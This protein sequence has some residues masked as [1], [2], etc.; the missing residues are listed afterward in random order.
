MR[1]DS[2][3]IGNYFDAGTGNQ[4]GFIARFGGQ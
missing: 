1:W 3:G 2:R 4:H